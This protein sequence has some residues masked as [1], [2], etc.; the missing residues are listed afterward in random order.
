MH[1]GELLLP[2]LYRDIPTV[3]SFRDNFY[4]ES[5]LG[6]FLTQADAI[7]AVSDFSAEVIKASA[8]RVLPEL[9]NRVH[10]VLNGIDTQLYHP[11]DP[12]PTFR[13]F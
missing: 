6:S 9:K 12:A 1:D 7:I 4:P 3:T 13:R 10:T 11:S 2:Y 5:I 8:G